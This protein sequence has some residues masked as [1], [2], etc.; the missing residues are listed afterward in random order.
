[1]EVPNISINWSG[2]FNVTQNFR[3]KLSGDKIILPKSALEQLL[4]ASSSVTSTSTQY[5]A[6]FDSYNQF[7]DINSQTSKLTDKNQQLPQPLTF[8]LVNPKN[9]K[10]VYAGIQEFSAEEGEIALS[11]FLFEALNISDHSNQ[12]NHMH[13]YQTNDESNTDDEIPRIKVLAKQLPKG[14]FLRLRPLEAGY[15]P[16][17]WKSLLEKYLRENFTTL[18]RGETI[19]VQAP[20]SEVFRFLIDEV[21]PNGDGICVVDTDLEVDIEALNEE[22]ARE[23]LKQIFAKSFKPGNKNGVSAASELDMWKQIKGKVIEGEYVDYTLLSWDRSQGIVVEVIGRNVE[24]FV[25]PFSSRQRVPPREDEHVWGN[26]DTDLKKEIII[27]PPAEEMKMIEHFLISLH[28]RGQSHTPHEYSIQVRPRSLTKTENCIKNSENE[29]EIH[30]ENEVQ[31]KTCFKWLPKTNIFLHENFCSRN[32]EVCSLC[33]NVFQ[34][35]SQE[36]RDHWHCEHDKVFGHTAESKNNHNNIF[37]SSRSCPNCS[38]TAKNLI[39]L[40]NHRTTLCPGKIILC[41]FCHLEVPQ[42]GDPLYPSPEALIYNLTAH[43]LSDGARTTQCHLCSKIIRLRDLSNHM[44]YHKLENS[45]KEQPKICRNVYCC[46]TL[47][48]LEKDGKIKECKQL[49]E[50]PKNKLGLCNIC[51]GP[52]YVNMYDPEGK[53][54][55]R[56]IERRYLSQLISG[57][58]K[59]WCRNQYCKTAQNLK[60]TA[61]TALPLVKPLVEPDGMKKMYFCVDQENNSSKIMAEIL[62]EEK[63]FSLEWC[64]AALEL[65]RNIDSAQI[66]LDNWAPKLEK[67]M[68]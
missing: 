18:T 57:C 51:F 64:V 31:C 15:N 19:T 28:A 33:N 30:D 44:K 59:S 62:A 50:T 1:M 61:K 35:N 47:D 52:F 7:S 14:K 54:L 65:R 23:T 6:N 37:H 68:V 9:G 56:R 66:W 55:R 24:L 8:L 49:G 20:R 25:S 58:G 60:L 21:S 5:E 4:A 43:E 22:Q 3:I 36:W 42:E 2:D 40:A 13:G 41:Q 29:N 34:K 48:S 11:P 46:R 45:R 17:D 32:N 39:D 26:F 27:E 53:A 16:A 10:K 12:S 38:Y 67:G 63:K